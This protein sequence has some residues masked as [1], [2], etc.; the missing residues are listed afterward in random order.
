[1]KPDEE[2]KLIDAL[3]SVA[4]ENDATSPPADLETRVLAEFD[5]RQASRPSSVRA[6]W[7]LPATAAALA[8]S[9]ALAVFLTHRP[10]PPPRASQPPFIA[11]PYVAPP[12]P[13]ERTRVMRMDVPVAALIAA[14]LEAHITASSGSVRADVLLGQDG[15]PLAIRLVKNAI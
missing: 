9:A 12:A 2:Q 8:A 6:R 11:I 5:A 15:R 3:R 4:A 13:Y 1:M 7:W 14:G 10:A